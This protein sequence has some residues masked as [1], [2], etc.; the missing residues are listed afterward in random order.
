MIEILEYNYWEH[1]KMTKDLALMLPIGHPKRV[2]IEKSL[3]ELQSLI[4]K[5]KH[6]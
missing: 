4:T 3:N 5:L 6:K 1:F 2:R